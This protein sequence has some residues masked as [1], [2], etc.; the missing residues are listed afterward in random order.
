LQTS[1]VRD[2]QPFDTEWLSDYVTFI[3]KVWN[4][5]DEFGFGRKEMGW[6]WRNW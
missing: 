4:V 3:G 1:W 2:S 5:S 6:S